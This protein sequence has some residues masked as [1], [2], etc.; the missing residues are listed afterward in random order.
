MSILLDLR[1]VVFLN[2]K[3]L[4]KQLEIFRDKAFCHHSY[5]KAGQ[6]WRKINKFISEPYNSRIAIEWSHVQLGHGNKQAC[7]T[8][9]KE[10]KECINNL[11]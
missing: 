2:N 8:L 3:E 9:D 1:E 6:T 7:E 4:I 11:K 10:V 5:Y